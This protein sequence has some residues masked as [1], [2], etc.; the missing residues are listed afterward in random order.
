MRPVSVFVD[1]VLVERFGPQIYST[2]RYV[3]TGGGLTW[4]QVQDP[5]TA[6]DVAYLLDWS[7]SRA[8]VTIAA[9]LARWERPDVCVFDRL[10]ASDARGP[11]FVGDRKHSS[12][13]VHSTSTDE[14]RRDIIFDIFWLLTGQDERRWPLSGHQF[15]DLSSAPSDRRQLLVE[16]TASRLATTLAERVA[17]RT[18]IEPLARWP[19][20]KRA[21]AAGS[22]DVDYP[23]VVR[24]LEPFRVLGRGG[25]RRWKEAVDVGLGK[26]HHWQFAAW[27]ALEA[28]LGFRSA[29]YFSAQCGS[30][31]RRALVAPDVLYDIRRPRFRRLFDELK[32]EGFEIGLHPSYRACERADGV[33]RE[34]RALEDAARTEVIGGRHH[35]WRLLPAD[36]MDTL[37]QH[38]RAGLS[39]DASLTFDRYLGWRRA[40][41]WPFFPFDPTLGRD[42]T[43][44][45]LPTGWMD[46][47]LFSRARFNPPGEPQAL[48]NMLVDTVVAQGGCLLVDVHEYVYDDGLFPGWAALYRGLFETLAARRDVWL[49][50]PADVARHWRTRHQTIMGLSSGLGASKT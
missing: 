45:Q 19:D 12:M 16:G 35:Y 38:E 11:M 33:L 18:Q 20:G 13:W 8:R 14:C 44:L 34:K 1:P 21:A 36:P 31:T 48:L 2:L 37:R 41:T 22:H 9:D 29:F 3:L 26:R 28:S 32:Q 39:Y 30:L 25:A 10:D 24:C 6:C 47:Q 50:T 27:T 42:L 40:S 49:A 43:T 7:R 17:T 5:D 23:E 15:I 4:T 46:D